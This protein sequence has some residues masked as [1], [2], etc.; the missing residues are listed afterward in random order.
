MVEIPAT[1]VEDA[2]RPMKIA[3]IENWGGFGV[4]VYGFISTT[5]R[6]IKKQKR[7]PQRAV[8][9]HQVLQRAI[10][11]HISPVPHRSHDGK[12]KRAGVLVSRVESGRVD[13][14]NRGGIALADASLGS[15]P[16]CWFDL[17]R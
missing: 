2:M 13:A 6:S 3:K 8:K 4:C 11:L 7:V 12:E 15:Y 17:A 9:T 14:D 16:P 10:W 5:T 1:I